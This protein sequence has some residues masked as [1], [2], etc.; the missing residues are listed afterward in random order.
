MEYFETVGI[1][2]LIIGA[3]LLFFLFLGIR[4][5]RRDDI[6]REQARQLEEKL[7]NEVK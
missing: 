2:K 5:K 7:K 4:R 1:T 3:V 6:E